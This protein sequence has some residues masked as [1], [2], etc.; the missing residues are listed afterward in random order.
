MLDKDS[1]LELWLEA[2]ANLNPSWLVIYLR[3]PKY[4][5]ERVSD[6]NGEPILPRFARGKLQKGNRRN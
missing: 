1:E 2:A 4:G 3:R 5:S 6:L